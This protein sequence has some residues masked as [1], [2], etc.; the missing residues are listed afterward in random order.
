M[1]KNK[2]LCL[3]FILEKNIK[4]PL[5]LL[6]LVISTRKTGWR[7]LVG[8]LLEGQLRGIVKCVLSCWGYLLGKVQLI[9][10]GVFTRLPLN[11]NPL[12]QLGSC[13]G[14]TGSGPLV[15]QTQTAGLM[16]AA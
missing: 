13:A 6:Q 4:I 15:Q 9:P 14:A 11:F 7:L 5:I 12:L 2:T 3:L 16:S 1:L 10:V 8:R